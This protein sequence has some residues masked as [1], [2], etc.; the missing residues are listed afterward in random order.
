MQVPPEI[1]FKG[2]QA[3]PYMEK[4][5]NRGMARLERV[6]NYIISTRIALEW[7]QRRHQTG[8]NYSMRIDIRLPDHREI[9]VK[10]SSM[11][12]M[13]APGE[14]AELK[15]EI[16]VEIASDGETEIE[17]KRSVNRT[18]VSRRVRREEELPVLINH[19]F[20]SALREL[21]KAIH[22]LRRDVKV[23]AEQKTQAIV[24]KIFPEKGYGF[25]RSMAGE[26]V[27]FHKNS[28]IHN[29]WEH[30]TVGTGVRYTSELGEKGVQATMVESV[31]KPGAVEVHEQLHELPVVAIKKPLR[32]RKAARKK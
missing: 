4:L 8:N 29:H 28:V 31:E 20:D 10:R 5:I 15:Q 30:L 22:K 9:V 23:H 25:L 16:E 27:Y 13:K 6:C 17:S 3:T 12:T 11:A 18:P 26:E 14:M 32:A 2:V 21:E 1:V 7:T 19:T 24:E